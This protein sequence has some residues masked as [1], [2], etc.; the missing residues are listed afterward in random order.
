MDGIT[1]TG[2]SEGEARSR[3]LVTGDLKELPMDSRART[4]F[5]V[6]GDSS[7]APPSDSQG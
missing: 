7:F 4:G 2:N 5:E 1:E 3:V 6:K